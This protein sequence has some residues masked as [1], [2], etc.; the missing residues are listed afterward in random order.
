M[1]VIS[2]DLI[3]LTLSVINKLHFFYRTQPFKMFDNNQESHKQTRIGTK[4]NVHYNLSKQLLLHVV[5]VFVL[6]Q[7][8]QQVSSQKTL[9]GKIKY[10][11]SNNDYILVYILNMIFP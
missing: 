7:C 8:V 10:L 9:K 1:D 3:K 4:R 6:C 11:P 2:A 5:K